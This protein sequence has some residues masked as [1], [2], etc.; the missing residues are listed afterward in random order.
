LS[1]PNFRCVLARYAH[2]HSN[3]SRDENATSA[4]PDRTSKCFGNEVSRLRL[5]GLLHDI[6]CVGVPTGIWDLPRA[7]SA[8]ERRLVELHSWETQRVLGATALF[9]ELATL[10][11][12]AHERLD[13]SGYY[14]GLPP[15]ALDR[16]ARVLGGR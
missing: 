9:D 11:S 16:A 12:S 3:T 13:G 7:L 15:S 4:K 10:A 14:R 1:N 8:P 2:C 6:G 5:A